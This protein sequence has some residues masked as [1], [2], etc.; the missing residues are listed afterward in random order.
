MTAK[1]QTAVGVTWIAKDFAVK[2]FYCGS[3]AFEDLQELS[4]FVKQ[5]SGDVGLC[6]CFSSLLK[7]CCQLLLG[8]RGSSGAC[9]DKVVFV[10]HR[11]HSATVYAK[12]GGTGDSRAAVVVT[13]CCVS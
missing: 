13:T 4:V 10:R 6:V 9:V 1:Q 2:S 5:H 12:I 11:F 7:Q 8:K 3:F